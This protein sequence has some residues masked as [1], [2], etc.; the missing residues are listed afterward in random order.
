MMKLASIAVQTNLANEVK[1]VV[2]ARNVIG[3]RE[4]G[5]GERVGIGVAGDTSWNKRST[6]YSSSSDSGT[7]FLIGLNTK[8]IVA[9][10]AMSRRCAKC[11]RGIPLN[12]HTGFCSKN[13]EGSS[14]GME[15][16]GALRNTLQI[17]NSTGGCFISKLVMDDDSTTKAILQRQG[18]GSGSLPNDHPII[19][20]MA[21]INHRIKLFTSGL[22][23]LLRKKINV[24][25]WE[26][27]RPIVCDTGNL[28]PMLFGK[29]V[30]P[31]LRIF[32]KSVSALLNISLTITRI[33]M[34]NGVRLKGSQK[35]KKKF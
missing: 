16:T 28:W 5:A 20:F 34:R 31:L 33:V 22:F 2:Q 24:I 29:T 8:K 26:S 27:Q 4:L 12:E 1:A 6:G 32:R 13:Y 18:D 11:E 23:E 19:E 10:C 15:A 3:E 17:F 14:G 35:R 21:D 7:H 30:T 25:A 9:Y